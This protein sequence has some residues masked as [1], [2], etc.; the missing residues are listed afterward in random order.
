VTPRRRTDPL[1]R[2]KKSERVGEHAGNSKEE[3]MQTFIPSKLWLFA[4]L[5]AS[6]GLL[7]SS[8]TRAHAKSTNP[9]ASV[10]FMDGYDLFGDG[11][12]YVDGQSSIAAQFYVSGSGDL[13]LNLINSARR[14]GGRYTFL[15]CPDGSGV[16]TPATCQPVTS[17]DPFTD[18]WFVNIHDISNMSVAETRWTQAVFTAALGKPLSHS[19]TYSPLWNFLWCNDGSGFTGDIAWPL[20]G[21]SASQTDGSQMV[22]VYR[23]T[24]S[25]GVKSWTVTSY[26]DPLPG[27]PVG[28][29]SELEEQSSSN[30]I[31]L[32]GLYHTS[33]Q[34]AVVCTSGC[35]V[36]P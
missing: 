22:S 5:V 30:N 7:V 19:R 25:A 10:V 18:G 3:L 31:T 32:H 8:A 12:A 24:S 36:F 23:Y 15:R 6:T 26:A 21:C 27:T 2:R 16:T 1:R 13:T 9:S 28:P 33:F 20:S 35:A 17:S 34:L 29:V 14:F 4:G 11:S